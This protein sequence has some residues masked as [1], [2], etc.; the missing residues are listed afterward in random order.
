MMFFWIVPCVLIYYLFKNNGEFNI[1]NDKSSTGSA[2]E[3]LKLKFVNGE[4]DEET[5]N[6]KMRILKDK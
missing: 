5:F 6:K 2:E 4:I 3:I 1:R